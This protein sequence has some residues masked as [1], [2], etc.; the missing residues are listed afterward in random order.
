MTPLAVQARAARAAGDSRRALG[1]YRML[2]Q[3]GGAAG[4]NAEYEIGRVLRDSLHQPREAVAAWRAYRAQH[5]RGLL[6]IESDLSVIETLV[7]VGD[8]AG[9]VTEASDFI[10]R[11]PESER[12]L[13]VA[14]LAGDLLR[15]RGDCS[16][17]VNAYNVALATGRA[18]RESARSLTDGISFHRSACLMRDDTNEGVVALKAYLQAFP[19]GRFRGE[20]QRLLA[21]TQPS[22]ATPAAVSRP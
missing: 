8:K 10:R 12:R 3:R 5:P 17:A 15:E 21:G 4:E 16:G 11:Y 13:E 20:A 14:R 2:A 22:P 1:L 18:R 6:R 19:G 9:A 7:S